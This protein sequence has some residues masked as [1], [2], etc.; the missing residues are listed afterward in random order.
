M[1]ERGWTCAWLQIVGLSQPLHSYLLPTSVWELTS[2]PL[3]RTRLL[4]FSQPKNQVWVRSSAPGAYKQIS[5]AL[6]EPTDR[7]VGLH[8]YSVSRKMSAS[9][10]L[11]RPES[12][13]LCW[14]SFLLP[15]NNS[16][17]SWDVEGVL[18]STADHRKDT[19]SPVHFFLCWGNGRVLRDS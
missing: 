13:G 14:L 3:E 9:P 12:Q 1:I 15:F 11:L 10:R 8:L 7:T 18:T 16:F 2:I 4:S 5:P 19:W 17:I 6:S